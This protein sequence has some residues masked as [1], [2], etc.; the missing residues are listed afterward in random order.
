[1]NLDL[2]FMLI[3]ISVVPAWLMLICV[4]RWRVTEHLVHSLLYP[5]ILGGAYTVLLGFSVFGGMGGEGAG[6][7]T[8]EA[9]R[10]LFA[11]DIGIGGLDGPRCAPPRL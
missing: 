6:F 4:P 3:N 9:V 5:L 11:V 8:V 10:V 1:M 2:A 7:T